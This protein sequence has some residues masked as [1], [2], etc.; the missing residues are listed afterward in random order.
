MFDCKFCNSPCGILDYF[1]ADCTQL[2]KTISL[3][4]KQVHTVVESIFIRTPTQQINKISIEMKKQIE[5]KKKNLE[6]V[7]TQEL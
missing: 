4:G 5:D 1:C 3:Y 7:K 6:K 2:Q